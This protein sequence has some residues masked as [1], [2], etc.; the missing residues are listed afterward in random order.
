MSI[1]DVDSSSVYNTE[2]NWEKTADRQKDEPEAT[3]KVSRGRDEQQPADDRS[4]VK[5]VRTEY[6]RNVKE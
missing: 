2:R 5:P 4:K 3:G 6:D 1:N